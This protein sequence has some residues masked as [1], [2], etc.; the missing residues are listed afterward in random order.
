[1]NKRIENNL[2]VRRQIV[3]AL[4]TLLEKQAF[5]EISVISIV[6]TAGVARQSYYRNFSSKEA[7]VEEFYASIHQ[8]VL[9]ELA[10]AATEGV[11]RV[12]V[13]AILHALYKNRKG[14]LQLYRAGFSQKNL[15]LINQYMEDAAGNMPAHSLARYHLYCFAGA[16]FNT[17]QIWLL[18]GAKEPVE[19]MARLICE[20]QP[21]S[22]SV[23]LDSQDKVSD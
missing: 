12:L 2:R 5:S 6:E 3:E 18:G 4:L 21:A 8:A 19:D 1:M 14:I 7:I 22:L 15:E 20:F 23:T 16:I 9:E 13:E 17:A 11:N 10:S